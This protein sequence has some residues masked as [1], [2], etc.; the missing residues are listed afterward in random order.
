MSIA[1]RHVVKFPAD[2]QGTKGIEIARLNGTFFFKLNY[3][4]LVPSDTVSSTVLVAFQDPVTGEIGVTT[5][6]SALN[7][8]ANIQ[9][10]AG[11]ST[12][13]DKI[14]YWNGVNSYSLADFTA[15]ARSLIAAGN[16]PDALAVLGAVIGTDVQP[17]NGDLNTIAGLTPVDNDILQRKAGAWINRTPAQIKTDFNLK[18]LAEK[19]KISVPGDINYSGTP[20]GTKFLRDDG[21][22]VN[23][24]GGGDMLKSSYDPSSVNG[25]AFDGFPVANRTALKAL[26]TTKFGTVYLKEA[27]RAGQFVW[28][29][30][31][32][33]AQVASDTQEG[34]YVKATAVAATSGA[35]VR[36]FDG[37][38]FAEWFGAKGDS[39]DTDN[40]SAIQAAFNNNRGHVAFSGNAGRRY[41][42]LGGVAVPDWLHVSGMAYNP[43]RVPTDMPVTIQFNLASGTALALGHTPLF[44]NISFVNGSGSY[45]DT[46]A[47]LSG[48]TAACM[49]LTDNVTVNRCSFSLWYQVFVL[50]AST[51]YVKTDSVEF[52]RCTIGY[53][54]GS[55]APYDI[56]IRSPI[57]RSTK[58][59]FLGNSSQLARNIKI[60]GGSIEGYSV[61]ANNFL[62]LSIFGTYFESISQRA[63]AI[64]IDPGS[65]GSS[66]SLFGCLVY[67]DYTARFVNMSGLANCGLTG[68]G[69][70]FDGVGPS[71]GTIYYLPTSG[72][73]SLSG[74]RFGLGHPNNLLYVDSLANAFKFDGIVMPQLPS[75]NTQAGYSGRSL[76]SNRGLVM[77]QLTAAPSSPI[78]GMTVMADGATWDPLSRS[79]GRPYWVIWQGDR[80]FS[81]SGA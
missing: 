64:P 51:Y 73:V 12:S 79:A 41:I 70:I 19:D 24:P 4:P 65:N 37:P 50:G 54:V 43:G 33:S 42:C 34:L 62:D 6:S 57:S 5:L 78:S 77:P 58:N 49:S 36:Q 52:N 26:D 15:F 8:N 45:N 7:S 29:S 59:F 28:T 25:N 22:F 1:M 35:W 3:S 13:G 10:I 63:G 66:V 9:A 69:N 60:F 40:T 18:A 46:T 68:S 74:D 80:W 81:L 67:L 21:A 23:L 47:E 38:V 14:G 55:A 72:S 2:V 32:Y 76:I 48:T 39:G 53:V 17:F 56:D 71:A 20:D 16:G 30:G 44:E 27:G 11:A 31:D 61:I 75:G